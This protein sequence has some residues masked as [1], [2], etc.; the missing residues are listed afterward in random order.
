MSGP[1][2]GAVCVFAAAEVEP[3]RQGAW[4]YPLGQR[5]AVR[6]G[7]M[8]VEIRRDDTGEIDAFAVAEN[9]QASILSGWTALPRCSRRLRAGRQG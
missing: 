3:F 8:L 9:V 5:S 7:A 4:R 2:D 6:V 1:G